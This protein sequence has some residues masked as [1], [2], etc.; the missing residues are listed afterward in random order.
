MKQKKEHMVAL[1]GRAHKV[2]ELLVKGLEWDVDDSSKMHKKI[3]NSNGTFMAVHVEFI[4]KHNN[5]I[6]GDVFSVAHH[7][8]QN[9]DT[10]RDP[11]VEFLRNSDKFYPIYFR[12][13]GAGGTEQKVLVFDGEGHVTGWRPK[14]QA[15]I[16][17]FC[18]QVWMPNIKRQQGLTFLKREPNAKSPIRNDAYVLDEQREAE[19]TEGA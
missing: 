12:Q 3:D 17:S 4:N 15:E 9:G 2:M 1:T 14:M 5:G 19:K 11:D 7:Y 6:V 8:E 10:M 13:D 16:A 18:N